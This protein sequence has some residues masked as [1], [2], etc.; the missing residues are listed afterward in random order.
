M[1]TFE[2]PRMKNLLIID[3]SSF[4]AKATELCLKDKYPSLG[5]TYFSSIESSTDFLID[6]K[7]SL[8]IL[9]DQLEGL[10]G[11]EALPLIKRIIPNSI[12]ILTASEGKISLADL[13][14]KRGADDY[15]I[16]DDSF[17]ENLKK[18]M[19]RYDR[20]SVSEIT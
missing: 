14:F 3:D 2:I 12:I 8:I 17:C 20:I 5:L 16:K 11:T 4:F 6:F 7:P 19:I 1:I 18:M 13:A 10:N 9:D 15:L